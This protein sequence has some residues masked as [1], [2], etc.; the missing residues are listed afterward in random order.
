MEGYGKLYYQSGKLAY[1]GEWKADQFKG[2]GILY[3][4][5]PEEVFGSIDYRSFEDIG[6][7]WTKYEGKNGNNLGEFSNDLKDGK[8]TLYFSNGERFVGEFQEDL[9]EG[10]GRYY[11]RNGEVVEGKW[12][13]N[14]L[15]Y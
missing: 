14:Q 2:K 1:E 6:E 10:W 11:K 15:L 7:Y 4:E 3:N 5:S 12:G 8:G 13:N 9:A